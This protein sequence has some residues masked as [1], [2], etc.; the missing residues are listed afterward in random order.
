MNSELI[1][2]Y[3]RRVDTGDLH[4]DT[5]QKMAVQ[6]FATLADDV[7]EWRRSS[8]GFWNYF[9]PKSITPPKGIYLYGGVGRGKTMLMDMFFASVIGARKRRVHFHEFMADVHERIGVARKT[10]DGDPIPSVAK[11]LAEEAGLLCFDEWI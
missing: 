8:N 1:E 5:A 10:V 3:E 7:A 2:M 4:P 11:D 9:F 6:R